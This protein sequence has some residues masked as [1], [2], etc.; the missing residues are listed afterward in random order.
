MLKSRFNPHD[1]YR[2]SFNERR[3]YGVGYLNINDGIFNF[4]VSQ[5]AL[6]VVFLCSFSKFE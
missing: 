6:K 2:G 5:P 3:C 4:K 1:F